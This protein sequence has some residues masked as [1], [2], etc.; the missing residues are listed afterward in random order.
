MS[1]LLRCFRSRVSAECKMSS[2][3]DQP[4]EDGTTT[5]AVGQDLS[6]VA[7]LFADALIVSPAGG[8]TWLSESVDSFHSGEGQSSAMQDSGA[9]PLLL[10]DRVRSGYCS[11]SRIS[12]SSRQ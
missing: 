7:L 1:W 5:T 4:D 12:L 9:L 3:C 6:K 8:D 2:A 10:G 11:I